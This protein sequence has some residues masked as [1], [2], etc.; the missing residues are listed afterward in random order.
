MTKKPAEKRLAFGWV[1][2]IPIASAVIGLLSVWA[3]DPKAVAWVSVVILVLGTLFSL[4][5]ALSMSNGS[6]SWLV[7]L[8]NTLT[9]FFADTYWSVLFALAAY[10]FSIVTIAVELIGLTP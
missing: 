7:R 6:P 10:G 9:V 4:G 5:P 8:L 3:F 2:G 1:L